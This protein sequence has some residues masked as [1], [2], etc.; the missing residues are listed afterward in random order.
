MKQIDMEATKQRYLDF[1]ESRKTL[2]ISSLDE[3]AIPFISYA[4]YV[5]KDG[6]FYIYIS[7]ISDHYRYVEANDRIHVMLIADES[8][9]QNVF[10][11]ERARWSCSTKNLGNAGHED[12]FALF[13]ET[14]NAK[15]MEMLRG[16]DFSL[17]E[18]SPL[19]GRYVVGFGQAFDVDLPGDVFNHVEVDRKDK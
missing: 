17:F 9:S 12:I 8:E 19:S 11:R 2:V 6:K 14:F 16:L 1:V 15:L 18:L 13:N 4:P 10:A 7:K 3:Y 5:K